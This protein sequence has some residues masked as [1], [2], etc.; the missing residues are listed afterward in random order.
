MSEEFADYLESA[1]KLTGHLQRKM[2]ESRKER[3]RWLNDQIIK[4]RIGAFASRLVRRKTETGR[5]VIKKEAYAYIRK[6]IEKESE[7]RKY[8]DEFK[9]I[10]AALL[11]TERQGLQSQNPFGSVPFYLESRY[12]GKR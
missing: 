10:V 9:G 12:Q 7:R 11:R 6:H 1:R 2:E 5:E 3:E 8:R 4:A